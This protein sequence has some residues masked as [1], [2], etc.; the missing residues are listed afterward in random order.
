MAKGKYAHIDFTPPAG[1][2]AAAKKGLEFRKKAAPS[3]KGGLDVKEASKQ[4]IGSGVQRAS[5]LS[6]GSEMSPEVVR[7]MDAFFKR[8]EK[9]KAIDPQYKSTP[10]NDKGYVAWL[11]W[12][13]DA[14]QAWASKLVRQ[15][16]AADEADHIK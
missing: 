9:N 1:V 8:H 4:G 15:M 6:N 13:G 10:W 2:R 3:R 16:N 11:L 12:G 14:G 5:D 7:R